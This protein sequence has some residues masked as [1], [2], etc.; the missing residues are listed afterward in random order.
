MLRAAAVLTALWCAAASAATVSGSVT[1]GSAGIANASVRL[2]AR[3]GKWFNYVGNGGQTVTANAQGVFTFNNVPAGD[4]LVDA[5]GGGL[6]D[7]WYDTDGTGYVAGDADVITVTASDTRSGVDLVLEPSGGINAQLRGNGAVVSG[8]QVRA[9]LVNDPRV[10]HNEEQQDPLHQGEISIRGLPPGTYRIIVHDSASNLEDGLSTAT[11][12]V[13]A[14]NLASAA[15]VNLGTKAT[16]PTGAN[17]TPLTGT[18][19]AVARGTPYVSPAGAAIS[20]RNGGDVDFYCLNAGAGARFIAVAEGTVATEAGGSHESPW[21]DPVLSVWRPNSGGMFTKLLEDDDSGPG[22]TDSRVDTGELSAAGPVCFGVTTYGDTGWTG[23]NQNSGGN[24][25]LTVTYGNRGPGVTAT[26]G[27]TPVGTSI[28]L[29]EGAQLSINLAAIDP[30]MDLINTSYRMVGASG[31]VATEGTL[32]TTAGM[33]TFQYVIPQTAARDSPYVLTLSAADAEITH[34]VTVN[35]IVT[36]VNV[37]PS[38]PLQL[39][40]F[41]GGRVSSQTPAL[42]CQESFD[43][44]EETLSYDFELFYGDAGTAAQTGTVV[45]RDGGYNP[46]AGGFAPTASFMTT[47]IPENTRGRWRVRAFDGHLANG[48]SPWSP[49]GT[50][51][52]DSAN[53]APEAPLLEKP[54]DGEVVLTRRPTLS[55]TPPLDPEDDPFMMFF[56]VAKDQQFTMSVGVSP[57]VAVSTAGPTTMWTFDKDLEWGA[58]YYARAW[59]VDSRNAKGLYSNINGF[60]VRANVAPSPPPF[61]EPA[62]GGACMGGYIDDK[63]ERVRIGASTDPEMDAIRIQLRVFLASEDPMTDAPVFDQTRLQ[64]GSAT[65]FDTSMVPVPKNLAHRFQVRAVD[66]YGASAWND[67]VFTVGTAP[68]VND[69]G[70]GGGSGGEGD[71]GTGGGGAKTKGG[72]GCTSVEGLA[73]LG[74]LMAVVRLRR[75]RR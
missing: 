11:I 52:V 37:P 46:D 41:D 17:N 5:R 43:E 33:S 24:Y 16:D 8:L 45:G 27:G 58:K 31:A 54:A 60:T 30:E 42:V 62:A 36:S 20:P 14:G 13:T 48:Y 72:C 7:R 34:S 10:H 53:D 65:E 49:F 19:I 2:W 15:Q 69:G 26:Q 25:K 55:V 9:E 1:N 44:D 4:Y 64:S 38:V 35:V 12:N 21:V 70:T 18:P 28:T 71:G 63:P 47:F 75:G 3:N 56:E 57:A 73:G 23:M 6:T 50:F 40:A 29:A 59:A 39:S 68:V 61:V 66:D 67:C 32:T 22:S 74:L 51:T